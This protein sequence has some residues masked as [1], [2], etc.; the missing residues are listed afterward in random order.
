MSPH[1]IIRSF[2]TSVFVLWNVDIADF[3]IFGELA[4]EAL[5]IGS[6]GK[7]VDLEGGHPRDVWRRS[8]GHSSRLLVNSRINHQVS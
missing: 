5:A 7:V 3:S 1:G 2:F 6:I 8:S 4:S